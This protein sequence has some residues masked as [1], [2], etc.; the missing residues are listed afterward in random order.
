MIYYLIESFRDDNILYVNGM[1]DGISSI[2]AS[3]FAFIVLGDRLERMSQY[4]GLIFT[5]IGVYLLRY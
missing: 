5:I 1:W 2:L 3:S 4:V